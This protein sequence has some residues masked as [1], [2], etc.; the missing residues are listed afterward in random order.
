MHFAFLADLTD[1]FPLQRIYAS[2]RS[3]THAFAMT[4]VYQEISLPVGSLAER[5]SITNGFSI[6]T[7]ISWYASGLHFAFVAGTHLHMNA[8][9]PKPRVD[10]CK[11]VY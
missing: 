8:S 10:N 2:T 3:R 7:L 5:Q 9:T 11:L 4:G 1:A 6:D